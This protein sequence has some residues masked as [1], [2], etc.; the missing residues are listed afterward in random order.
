MDTKWKKWKVTI[1]AAMFV[2]GVTLLLSEFLSA[3]RLYSYGD[4]ELLFDSGDYQ[5]TGEFRNYIVRRLE[6]LLSAAVDGKRWKYYGMDDQDLGSGLNYEVW[7]ADQWVTDNGVWEGTNN[8][9]SDIPMEQEAVYEAKAEASE[10]SGTDVNDATGFFSYNSDVVYPKTLKQYMEEMAKNKNLR[11][12]VVYKKKLCYTN[13][14]AFESKLGQAWDGADFYQSLKPEEYNF[15]LWFNEH[16]DG[17]V[18]IVKDGV[19][20]DVYGNGVYED[21]GQD[22]LVPGYSNFS[23]DDSVNDAVIFLAAAKEPKL[24]MQGNYNEYGQLQYGGALYYQRQDYLM[25]RRDFRTACLW[26]AVGGILLLVSLLLHKN[27]RI[28]KQQAVRFLGRFWLEGKLLFYLLLPILGVLMS[29]RE[30]LVE[31]DHWIDG[32]YASFW[33]SLCFMGQ[34]PTVRTLL[35]AGFWLIFVIMLDLR[36]N[37]GHQ[38]KPLFDSLRMKGLKYPLQKRLMRRY[39]LMLLSGVLALL[40]CVCSI[41]LVFVQ[42]GGHETGEAYVET[43]YSES[44]SFTDSHFVMLL[45]VYVE[46]GLLFLAV[47]AGFMTLKKNARLIQD[48]GALSDQIAAVRSGDLAKPLQLPEDADLRQAVE[49]LNQIQHGLKEALQEQMRSERMK[50]ELVANVS[51]DIKTPLTSIISYV[52][53][54]KQEE[55]LPGHVQEFIQILGE[56]AERLKTIVQD[57]FEVSKAASGDLPVKLEALD[58]GKL[59]WQTLADMNTQIEESSLTLRTAIP[60]EPVL[61]VA[62]GQRLYRVFQNLIGNALKYSLVGSRVFLSLICEADQCIVCIKNTSG[63]E[64]NGEIDFTERFVRGDQSRTDGGN[65]LGLSIAKSF[66]E[67]CGGSFRVETNADLFS[68]TVSFAKAVSTE[69]CEM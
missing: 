30:E 10:A 4:M 28:A 68:V 29:R 3:A 37:W 54:L 58:L 17:K 42:A 51:H 36:G 39:R 32:G 47:L 57:V 67:A 14:E 33:E 62:D 49:N 45:L 38:K 11:Y 46:F 13:I 16:G 55:H 50:V 22:W 40:L 52:E 12:A 56:K 35:L 8:A 26:F 44:A 6:D 60:K 64:L 1:S 34:L 59:L 20:Q 69:Q 41:L 66:T 15:Y 5:K 18:S 43:L 19:E 65:G 53:L 7:G 25:R 24:Y 2:V 63:V 31:L 61:I 27:L 9:A 23:V 48:I 21:D